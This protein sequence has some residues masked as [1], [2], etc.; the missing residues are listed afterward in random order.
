MDNSNTKRFASAEKARRHIRDKRRHYVTPPPTGE[1]LVRSDMSGTVFPST[2][3]DPI[4]GPVL[5]DGSLNCKLGGEVLVG[6]LKGAKIVSLTLEERAT[7]PRSCTIWDACYGN[8]MSQALRYRA[9]EA[10][11]R[12][13]WDEL[14]VLCDRHDQVLVRLHI[15]GDFYSL[16]YVEMWHTL[17]LCYRNLNLFGFTAH[18]PDSLI[19][20]ELQSMGLTGRCYVRYSGR[21]GRW[22][23]FTIDFPTERKMIGD[24]LVCPE[25]RDAMNGGTG[26]VHCGSC[27]ACWSSDIPIVFVEH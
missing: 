17:L 24:A 9:G 15:L 27:A 6:R 14:A 12:A 22:G 4:N 16:K 19:G 26:M 3:T 13:I 23:S 2:L 21:T 1:A 25:Q 11:E 18:H 10:L 7:C 5:K 8:S 20:V